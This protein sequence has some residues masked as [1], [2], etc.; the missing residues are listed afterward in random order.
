[1]P[2]IQA[3]NETSGNTSANREVM[4]DPRRQ[5]RAS[6]TMHKFLLPE[7]EEIPPERRIH[8]FPKSRKEGLGPRRDESVLEN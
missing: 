8:N 6:N 1:M 7:V 3:P 2:Q 4:A 5:C